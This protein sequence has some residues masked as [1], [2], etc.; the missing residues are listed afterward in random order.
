MNNELRARKKDRLLEEIQQQ[1]AEITQLTAHWRIQ[2]APIDKGYRNLVRY[3]NVLM[4][5][6]GLMML[7]NIRSPSKM[8]RW[9]RRALNT[10]Q[11]FRLFRRTIN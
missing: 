7:Y 8:V 9:S 1:R 2:T 3:K 5:G 11:V 10:W 6:L 4:G